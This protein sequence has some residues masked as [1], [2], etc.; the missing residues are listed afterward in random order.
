M[1]ILVNLGSTLRAIGQLEN[2][3]DTLS[4]GLKALEQRG[5]AAPPALLNNL[6]LV[7]QDLGD[8]ETATILLG[9]AVKEHR[10]NSIRGDSSLFQMRS[11]EATEVSADDVG[12]T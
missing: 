2:A 7:F 9:Q 3:R 1:S 12:A 6:G 4:N 5:T 10:E 11:S 8:L